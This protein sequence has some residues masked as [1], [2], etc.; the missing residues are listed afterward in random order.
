MTI[1]YIAIT[2]PTKDNSIDIGL[3]RYLTSIYQYVAFALAVTSCT[4]L[5]VANSR[6]LMYI[7][8]SS[9]LRWITTL[10]PLLMAFYMSHNIISISRT[11]AHHCLVIFS[12]LMGFSLSSVFLVFTGESITRVLLTAALTFVVMSVYGYQCKKD[13]SSITSFLLMGSIGIFI[14]GISNIILHNTAIHF[15]SSVVG[16]VISTLFTA[17]DTQKIKELYYYYNNTNVQLSEKLGIYGALTL[18]MDFINLFVFLLQILG[19]KRN[20]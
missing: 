20:D 4:T 19:L 3:R 12:I 16:V 15:I 5:M 1:D 6:E 2:T 10:S 8:H 17:Y 7:V 9:P 13:L 11:T 18:Y 14:A